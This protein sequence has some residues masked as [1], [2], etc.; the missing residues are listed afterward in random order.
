MSFLGSRQ[1]TL[2]E[3]CTDMGKFYG[4]IKRTLF[5]EV[6]STGRPAI[7]FKNEYLKA[8]GITAR[9][10]N[11]IRIDLQAISIVQSRFGLAGSR[12]SPVVS[13]LS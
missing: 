2:Q 9:Q 10:F 13:S 4:R 11:A 5:K 12:T 8:F 7:S 1:F 3:F 6:Q